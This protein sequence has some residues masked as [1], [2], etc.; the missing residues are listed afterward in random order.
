MVRKASKIETAKRLDVVMQLILSGA[1]NEFICQSVANLYQISTRQVERY[2]ADCRKTIKRAFER[3]ADEKIHEIVAKL[4]FLYER[5]IAT[6]NIA[7]ARKILMDLSALNI[8]ALK[9]SDDNDIPEIE[10]ADTQQLLKLLKP[11]R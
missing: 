8:S 7:E 3:S 2:I 9:E 10:E 4:N 1:S 5:C 6:N 11:A